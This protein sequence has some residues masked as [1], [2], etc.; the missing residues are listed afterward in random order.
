MLARGN[1]HGAVTLAEQGAAREDG[2]SLLLLATW[3]LIGDP[4]PRDLPAARTLLARARQAG[5]V[6]AAM[7]EAA[8]TANGGGAPA[9]WRAARAILHDT[10]ECNPLAAAQVALLDA[11]TLTDDG[12]P[13]QSLPAEKLVNDGRIVRFPAL[14]TPAECAH[15]A[16]AGADMLRPTTVVDSKTGREMPHPIRTSDGAVIGPTRETLPVQAINRRIAAATRTDWRQGEALSLLRYAPGQQY[17][18]HLDT[19]PGTGNQRVA[20]VLVYLND[21]FTG[22]ETT[23]PHHRII[24][25]PRIG[26]ALMF[27]N[28]L[29]NGTP[30]RLSL[31]TGEPVTRGVKWLATRWIR[32]RPYS[33]WT[34]P[35]VAI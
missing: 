15:V 26:D 22:G 17:R 2:A 29:P 25:R 19:L 6:D 13:R 12:A 27:L 28:T 30:D 10:A 18:A 7:M 24:V 20:T 8:L 14:L 34:G 5:D 23:F 33:P 35:E 1:R 3:R 11:M 4:L 32:A 21:G 9:D 16:Q 31:H